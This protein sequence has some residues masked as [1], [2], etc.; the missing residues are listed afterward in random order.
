MTDA[1]ALPKLPVREKIGPGKRKPLTRAQVIMLCIRQIDAGMVRC[2]C[3]CKAPLKPKCIDEHIIARDTL[4]P[5]LADRIDNRALYNPECS[6][7]KTVVDAGIVARFR[8]IRGERGSQR[9]K[10]EKRGG[11]SIKQPAVS[12]LSKAYRAKVRAFVEGNG[13]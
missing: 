5:E 7:S 9:A 6:K 8:A 2:G 1:D 3:G 12:K 11:S 4:G 10:R 13:Q